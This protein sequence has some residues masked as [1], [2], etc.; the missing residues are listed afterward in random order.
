MDPAA[1]LWSLPERSVGAPSR[2]RWAGLRVAYVWIKPGAT[3]QL[4]GDRP[5]GG[6]E[7]LVIAH[8]TR[9]GKP[10]GRGMVRL[11]KTL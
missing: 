2:W 6:H 4:T 10:R 11:A 3:Y 7:C 1:G 5:A 9:K 8:Q